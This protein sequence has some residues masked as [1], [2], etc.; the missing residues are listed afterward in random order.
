MSGNDYQRIMGQSLFNKSLKLCHWYTPAAL[1]SLIKLWYF[2][3]TFFFILPN[4]L[5]I[6]QWKFYGSYH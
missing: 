4:K 1:K 2:L 3:G 5:K 6:I